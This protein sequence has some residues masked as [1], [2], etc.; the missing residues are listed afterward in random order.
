MRQK[1]PMLILWNLLSGDTCKEAGR[2]KCADHKKVREG[3]SGN[4]IENSQGF[5]EGCF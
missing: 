2:R 4:R 5:P 3:V 1:V